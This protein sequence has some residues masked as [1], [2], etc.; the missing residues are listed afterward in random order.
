M[1]DD[2]TNSGDAGV[3]G[4]R[5]ESGS[6][7]SDLIIRVELEGASPQEVFVQHGLTIGR[8]ASNAIAIDDPEVERIHAHV[9][10]VNGE[11]CVVCDQETQGQLL[12]PDG[13]R[14]RSL[15]LKPGTR[16]GVGP[17]QLI[18]ERRAGRPVTVVV[19]NAW[20][21]T[22]PRCR[23]ALV[24]L[25]TG[26]DNKCPNCGLEVFYHEQAAAEAGGGGAGFR[27]WLPRQVGP[28][29]IRAFVAQGGMGVVLRGRQDDKDH[30]AAIKLLR[31]D[32]NPAWRERFQV[33]VATL[34]RLK[35]PNVV[36]L[37]DHGE[38]QKLLWLAV[39]WIDG[40]SL[41]TRIEKANEKK[42]AIAIEE[43][44]ETI[45]QM[46]DGVEYLH[47][48]GVIH[49]DLKP[50]NVLIARDGAVKI[51]DVGIAR[52]VG[53]AAQNT[54]TQTGT[55]LGTQF[56]MAPEVLDGNVATA[57]S[58]IYGIGLIWY[59]FLTGKA[60]AQS[61]RP[62]QSLRKDT[63]AGWN[64][65][66]LKCL[67][68]EPA[69][70]PSLTDLKAVL[71]RKPAPPADLKAVGAGVAGLAMIFGALCVMFLAV[72]WGVPHV[73]G[74]ATEAW[75][76]FFP[77]PHV[78]IPAPIKWTNPLDLNSMSSLS[79]GLLAPTTQPVPQG[80]EMVT[81]E[82]EG[83]DVSAMLQLAQDY[84][85]RARNST[86]SILDQ[87]VDAEQADK[88]FQAASNAKGADLSDRLTAIEGSQR[89]RQE[90]PTVFSNSVAPKQ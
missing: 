3:G 41:A 87:I 34:K 42:E 66:I 1:P 75:D 23:S 40:Q 50:A 46:R 35:H 73:E 69:G 36:A 62:P 70:R 37:L 67:A 30:F 7:L 33:E 79:K 11:L 6:R 71:D 58:D 17:A 5:S 81:V 39:E 56:Y 55:L 18:C 8:N 64:G 63:P 4:R 29:R 44:R 54:A 19:G 86:T 88:W 72:A 90:F 61:P 15:T 51:V 83:G 57:K 68:P 43:I 53:G 16:F 13:G 2:T 77:P 85:T 59:E 26:S 76:H 47:L 21:A 49:R 20:E 48:A 31:V 32:S 9:E 22:C 65:A 45:R 24:D 80:D 60:R 25:P 27:G 38:D 84:E 78:V 82:A 89:V 28:Y 52:A 12:L 14:V 74:W 10:R